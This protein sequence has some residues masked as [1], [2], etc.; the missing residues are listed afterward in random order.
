[1]F[2]SNKQ[3]DFVEKKTKVPR[4]YAVLGV[5]ALYVV[6]VLFNTFGIGELLSN[7]A[8]FGY[9]AYLSMK[10]LRTTEKHDDSDL[11]VYWVVFGALSVAEYFSRTILYLVP[12]YYF[13]KTIFLL[14]LS[15]TTYRG[16]NFI[17]TQFLGP[18][19]EKFI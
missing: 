2:S 8:G 1:Q 6:N 12:F 10:A 3:L 5:G 4:S 9:P 7:L 18:M 14:Y 13:F 19:S 17:Y 16:A 15:S 11:L